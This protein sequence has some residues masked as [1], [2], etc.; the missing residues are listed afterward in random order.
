MHTTAFQSAKAR[1]PHVR[2]VPAVCLCAAD[3]LEAMQEVMDGTQWGP[4]CVYRRVDN[5]IHG[6]LHLD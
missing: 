6:E 3:P 5:M 2:V 4:E 1:Y